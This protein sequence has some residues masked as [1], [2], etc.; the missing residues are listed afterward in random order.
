MPEYR[1]Y[2]LGRD[3][4]IKNF[5]PIVCDDDEKAIEAA[6][7]LVDGCDVEL[8]QGARLITTLTDKTP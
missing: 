8:W 4:H 7:R 6:K 5:E 1:A 2:F 3:G